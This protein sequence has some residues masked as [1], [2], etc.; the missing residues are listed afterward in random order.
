MKK[1]PVSVH[2]HETSIAGSKIYENVWHCLSHRSKKYHHPGAF[3]GRGY[4]KSHYIFPT[5]FSPNL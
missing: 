1:H 2:K 5:E 3:L 4:K